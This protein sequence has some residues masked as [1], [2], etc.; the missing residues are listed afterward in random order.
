MRGH[1]GHV[2]R[3][4]DQVVAIGQPELSANRPADQGFGKLVADGE[5]EVASNGVEQITCPD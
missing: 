2:G 3:E 4:V 1:G 5:G